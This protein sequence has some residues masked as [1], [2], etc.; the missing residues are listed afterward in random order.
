MLK[1]FCPLSLVL[2]RRGGALSESRG[3]CVACPRMQLPGTSLPPGLRPAGNRRIRAAPFCRV[4]WPGF[5][6]IGLHCPAG[7]SAF[8]FNCK[9]ATYKLL[10]GP[11]GGIVRQRPL[12]KLRIASICISPFSQVKALTDYRNPVTKRGGWVR[13]RKR[14]C[15]LK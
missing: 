3:T 2:S 4:M 7:P 8:R 10:K 5:P 15:T 14:K 6:V 12:R 9:S 13:R 11:T 1:Q